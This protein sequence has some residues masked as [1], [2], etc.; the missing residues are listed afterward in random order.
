MPEKDAITILTDL[1]HESKQFHGNSPI[2]SQFDLERTISPGVTH[3]AHAIE[4]LSL[5]RLEE[6]K[7]QQD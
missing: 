4:Y 1:E 5:H 7:A 6:V 2:W 3:L